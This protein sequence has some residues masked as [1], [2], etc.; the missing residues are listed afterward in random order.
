MSEVF[1]EHSRDQNTIFKN[2]CKYSFVPCVFGTLSLTAPR[3][4]YVLL[5]K[6]FFDGFCSSESCVLKRREFFF[7]ALY[8]R[9][10]SKS[11]EN[12]VFG[13]GSFWHHFRVPKG[14]SYTSI[15][16]RIRVA[17]EFPGQARWRARR[18]AA[19]WIFNTYII[20]LIRI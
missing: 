1:Q 18:V 6:V 3:A 13:G 17:G 5:S 7:F 15:L 16:I 14:G 20:Q 2:T 19:H 4:R 12:S 11:I 9:P 8:K 10:G